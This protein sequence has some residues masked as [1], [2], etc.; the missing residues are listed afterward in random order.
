[1]PISAE[2]EKLKCLFTQRLATI[3][4]FFL[5]KKAAYL[6]LAFIF[7]SLK[8]NGHIPDFHANF[9]VQLTKHITVFMLSFEQIHEEVFTKHGYDILQT[10][11]LANT[12]GSALRYKLFPQMYI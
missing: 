3:P 4:A 1:M 10:L 12:N 7:S 9:K 5:D 8:G 11:K 6:D 2:I